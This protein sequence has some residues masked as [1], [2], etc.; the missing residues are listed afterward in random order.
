MMM[1]I[2][3][4]KTR[5]PYTKSDKETNCRQKSM[6][7]KFDQGNDVLIEQRHTVHGTQYMN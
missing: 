3:D 2:S 1:M 4:K 7:N 5:K 6:E